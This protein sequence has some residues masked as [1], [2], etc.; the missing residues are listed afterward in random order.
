MA[1]GDYT[2]VFMDEGG[3]WRWHRKAAN[4]KIIA[5]SGESFDSQR[6]AERA[7]ARA[8]DEEDPEA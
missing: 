1:D 8:Y 4:H 2:D 7:A 3:V 5:T 6:N